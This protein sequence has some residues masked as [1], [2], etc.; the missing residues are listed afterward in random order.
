MWGSLS[1]SARLFVS[2]IVKVLSFWC[3]VEPELVR[4]FWPRI[5]LKG[6]GATLLPRII[7]T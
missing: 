4:R 1:G 7:V 3:V 6:A 2:F 5:Q